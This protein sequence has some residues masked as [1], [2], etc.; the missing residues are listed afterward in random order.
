MFLDLIVLEFRLGA[1]EVLSLSVV[2]VRA[3][4]FYFLR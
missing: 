4:K 2:R 3:H 1:H